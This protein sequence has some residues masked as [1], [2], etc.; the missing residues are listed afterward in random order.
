MHDLGFAIQIPIKANLLVHIGFI[1]NTSLL[2][3]A[4]MRITLVSGHVDV[5][6]IVTSKFC[7]C[8]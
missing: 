7:R 2:F 4:K 8:P 3:D 5:P 1:V 6:L